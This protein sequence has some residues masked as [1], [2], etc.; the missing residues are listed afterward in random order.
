MLRKN[1]NLFDTNNRKSLKSCNEKCTENEDY[2]ILK[3]FFFLTLASSHMF[4]TTIL[5]VSKLVVSRNMKFIIT[6]INVID[7]HLFIENTHP[8][9]KTNAIIQ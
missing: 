9:K 1:A 6:K 7:K 5:N 4:L 2:N 8:E 3:L